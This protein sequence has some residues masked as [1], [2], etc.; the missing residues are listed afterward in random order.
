[1]GIAGFAILIV[2]LIVGL[3]ALAGIGYGVTK[4][5]DSV[6]VEAFL[7]YAMIGFLIVAVLGGCYL[8]YVAFLS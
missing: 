2:G 3:L 5:I 8:L 1:M 6:D 7:G 4:F